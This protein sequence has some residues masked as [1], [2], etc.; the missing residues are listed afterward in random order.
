MAAAR[1]TARYQM[2]IAFQVQA[3]GATRT[4]ETEIRN[5]VVAGWA[6]RDRAAIEHHI[7]ELAEL[8]VPRPSSVPLYY[9]IAEN[10]L[11]QAG[12]V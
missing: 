7:E 6:G 3:D 9:R 12:R 4:V 11:S 1:F 2:K 8:G 10:Q 5:L